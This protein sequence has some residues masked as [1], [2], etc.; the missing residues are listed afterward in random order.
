V[1]IWANYTFGTRV[2]TTGGVANVVAM[3][4]PGDFAVVAISTGLIPP[5]VIPGFANELGIDP[6]GIVVMVSAFMPNGVARF[7]F[8]VAPTAPALFEMQSLVLAIL[9]TATG[10]G[11]TSRFEAM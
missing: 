8:T 5:T 6:L 7:T 9:T 11:N 3:G 4:A 2:P 10:F 1:A